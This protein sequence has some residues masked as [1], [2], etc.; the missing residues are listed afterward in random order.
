MGIKS[1]FGKVLGVAL[2]R[3]FAA[4]TIVFKGSLFVLYTV[5]MEY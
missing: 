1:V 4:Y 3:Y 5:V 2:T